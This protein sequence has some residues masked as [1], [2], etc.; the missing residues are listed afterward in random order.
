MSSADRK[1]AAVLGSPIAHSL[2]PVI[3]RA[4]YQV[5]G[6]DWSYEAIDITPQQL[7]AFLSE[8]D[9]SWAGLSLTMPLKETVIDLLDNVD[10]IAMRVRSVNTV[11]PSSSGLTGTNTDVYGMVQGL[12]VAGLKSADTAT[13]LGAGATARSAVAA[14]ATLGVATL[15]VCARRL[16][17]AED[18]CAVA[19]EFG[20]SASAHGLD[21]APELLAVDLVISTL[22]RDIA[23]NWVRAIN[24]GGGALQDVSYY[25]WP[26]PLAAKWP[27]AVIA[28]G[29]DLLLWQAAE[30]VKLMTG[31]DAPVP[32]MRAA[33][34]AV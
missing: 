28:S 15:V 18:V 20:I 10:E 25:P 23:S 31:C 5:L 17:A 9:E 4:A 2:S 27:T 32:Q 19:A 7:P 29:R 16:D 24:S 13:I 11:L 8:L 14:A 34:D 33:L 6:L 3:H 22:P 21:P 12:S 30:Q 1:R 26:T